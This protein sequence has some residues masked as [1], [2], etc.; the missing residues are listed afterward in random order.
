MLTNEDKKE[1]GK[2][3]G[4]EVMEKV[5]DQKRV[6]AVKSKAETPGELDDLQWFIEGETLVH[7]EE[8]T[9]EERKIRATSSVAQQN[10]RPHHRLSTL[11]SRQLEVAPS[12]IYM[13]PPDWC[14]WTGITCDP[15]TRHI[16]GIEWS[17]IYINSGYAIGLTPIPTF[18]LPYLQSLMLVQSGLTGTLPSTL[19]T[20][21]RLTHLDLQGNTLSGSVPS[22]SSLPLQSL[23]LSKNN[24]TGNLV[25]V[26][27]PY[28][29]SS[30][31]PILTYLALDNNKITGSLPTTLYGLTKLSTLRLSGNGLTGTLSTSISKLTSLQRLFLDY[32]KLTGT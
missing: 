26:L 18:N 16:V 30:T 4:E 22:F 12:N 17:G 32:N 21:T 31:P 19:E 3:M 24:F 20:F 9:T 2:S 6:L 5:R 14:A 25:H 10:P 15:N 28:T 13:D 8:G 7:T 23:S 29:S 11:S 1:E 27:S